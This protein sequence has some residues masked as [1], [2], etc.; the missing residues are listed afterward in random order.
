MERKSGDSITVCDTTDI[1]LQ[2][3]IASKIVLDGRE[4]YI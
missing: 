4:T 3:L 1:G 2:D